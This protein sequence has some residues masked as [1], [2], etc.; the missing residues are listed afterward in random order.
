MPLVQGVALAE[1]AAVLHVV[2]VGLGVGL[3]LVLAEEAVTVGAVEDHGVHV[4]AVIG[5]A[6]GAVGTVVN[7]GVHV[8]AVI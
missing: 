8:G 6:I 5:A 7:H 2:V 4:G 3:D 1:G